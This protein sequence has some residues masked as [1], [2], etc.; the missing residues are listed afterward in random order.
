[1]QIL[2]MLLIFLLP[3]PCK[4][5]VL[6]VL[7]GAKVGKHVQIGWFATLTGRHIALGDY[8]EVRSLTVIQCD[9]DLHIGAYSII[10][11][12]TL[13]Y[14]C[15]G[16]WVG[17]HAYI[18]PQSLINCDEDVRL[19]THSALGARSMVYTHGSYLPYTEGYWVKFG[20][21]SVGDY[22]WCAAGVFLHPGITIGNNVFVNSRSVVT[23]D[24][25]DGEVV[26]GFPARQVTTMDRVQRKMTPRRLDSAAAQIIDHFADMVLER[27]LRAH[28]E[29]MAAGQIRF[30]HR[31]QRYLVCTAPSNGQLPAIQ[32]GETVVVI[33][34]RADLNTASQTQPIHLFDLTTMVTPYPI[35]PIHHQLD[36]F[37][38]RYYGVQ[39]RY[40]E[41]A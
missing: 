4:P 15:A 14:G 20:G 18:G 16:L 29:H 24:I 12:F 35:D 17:D 6:R 40:A 22:T 34:N 31:G 39:F 36:L 41:P 25:G 38:R 30:V 27:Q 5:F 23:Q 8:A 26:E 33:S 9:G 28:V 11:S 3:P 2:T 19:G 10:S 1:V 7:A 13:V 37:M 21:V 32:A